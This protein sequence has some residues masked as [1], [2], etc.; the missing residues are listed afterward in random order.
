MESKVDQKV[1][2]MHKLA[3]ALSKEEGITELEALTKIKKEFMDR[4]ETAETIKGMAMP[5][6]VDFGSGINGQKVAGEDAY[7]VYSEQTKVELR[8]LD[9]Q[10]KQLEAE[11]KRLDAEIRKQEYLDKKLETEEK[12]QREKLDREEKM[13]R[14]KLDREEKLRREEIQLQRSQKEEDS[15]VERDRAHTEKLIMLSTLTG[16]KGAPDEL[17]DYLKSQSESTKEFYKY[18]GESQKGMYETLLKTKETERDREWEW[19]KE[20]A[21]IEAEREVELAKLRQD[22]TKAANSTEILLEMLGEKFEALGNK[23]SANPTD[24]FTAQVDRHNKFQQSLINAAMP[25]LKAQGLS[26]ESLEKVRAQVGM[27]EKRQESGISKLYDVGKLIWKNYVEPAADK[28][29]KELSAPPPEV[30]PEVQERIRRE[31][32]AK[33]TQMQQENDILQ[34]QLEVEKKRIYDLQENRSKLESTARALGIIYNDTMT[35]DDLFN[36]IEHF[37]AGIEREIEREREEA[38]ETYQPQTLSR[39]Q[40]SAITDPVQLEDPITDPVQLQPEDPITDTDQPIEE[41]QIIE[42][43]HNQHPPP[44]SIEEELLQEPEVSDA[45]SEFIKEMQGS[46]KV[47]TPTPSKPAFERTE[48]DEPQKPSKKSRNKKSKHNYTVT[49]GNQTINIEAGNHHGAALS[50]A[51]KF[52]GGSAEKPS[53]VTVTD[54]GGIIK[55]YEIYSAQTAKGNVPRARVAK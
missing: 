43:E 51:N 40:A 6:I 49:D 18:Q 47:D 48:K 20:L 4:D 28:A 39:M 52:E 12:M 11:Q 8:R 44:S 7:T 54:D 42:T 13:Q 27:E 37:E 21:T 9:L 46:E 55:Q 5:R 19:K 14:E 36:V 15:K 1:N 24:D 53:K 2:M 25:I 26:E 34:K 32:A 50:A 17:M 38:L 29:Q 45:T 16:K 33:A 23:L 30:P 31:T 41:N 22:D 35:N 3:R 10:Q